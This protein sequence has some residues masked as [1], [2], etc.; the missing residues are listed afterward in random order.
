M[1]ALTADLGGALVYR[2]GVGVEISNVQ[3]PER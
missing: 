1:L 3:H 2:H